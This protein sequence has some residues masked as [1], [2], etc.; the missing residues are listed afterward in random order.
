MTRLGSLWY[1]CIYWSR[2][3]TLFSYKSTAISHLVIILLACAKVTSYNNFVTHPTSL[4][5]SVVVL[6]INKVK[7]LL[8]VVRLSL[9][10]DFPQAFG[11]ACVLPS[12][13]FALILSDPAS[14]ALGR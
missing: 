3:E 6:C 9:R 8:L 1:N 11:I 2:F 4:W 7:G 14:A 13:S 10:C 12:Y 5:R